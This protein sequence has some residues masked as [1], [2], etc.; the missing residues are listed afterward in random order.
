MTTYR[1]ARATSEGVVLDEQ[2]RDLPD[3]DAASDW[4]G[5][6]FLLPGEHLEAFRDGAGEPFAGRDFTRGVEVFR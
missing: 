1:F 4:M 5:A 6:E 2:V 3:D